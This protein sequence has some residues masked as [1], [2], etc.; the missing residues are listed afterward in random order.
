MNFIDIVNE[1][2]TT[3]VLFK[4]ALGGDG[5]TGWDWVVTAFTLARQYCDTSVK[6][7]L[8]EYNILHN[9][10]ITSNYIALIDTLKVRGLIDAI[11][12]QGHYFEFKSAA[13]LTPVYTWPISTLKSNL[14]RLAAIGLPIYIT[15]FDI[16]E[17]VDS[18][19]LQNYKTYFPIFWEHPA[20]KGITLWGY[21]EGNIWQGNA[22]LLKSGGA[23]RPAL[24]WLRSYIESPFAPVPI[25]PNGTTGEARNPL[26]V[27]HASN[28]AELYNVQVS[29][30]ST[31][32]SSIVLDTTVTDTT[33]QLSTLTGSTR[34]CWHVNTLNDQG[35]SEYSAT[36]S[37]KTENQIVSVKEFEEIPKEFKLSQNYPNPFNPPTVIN[38]QLPRTSNA[39]LKVYDM[40]GREVAT[41]VN[42]NQNAG[43]YNITFDARNLPS[44]VY[45]Y[46]INAENYSAV[47]KLVLMK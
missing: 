30:N 8:N 3:P 44:R 4:N 24:N 28:S 45:F 19:Q 15:E 22:Y 14:N 10:N 26:L 27:W 13:G 46:R 41:L 21:V 20:V 36:A 5:K 47:K 40:V 31:S 43:Y 16:N 39:N 29:I 37:F 9:D 23:E 35:T 11:G 17:P 25:S 7:I 33:L 38:Y 18:I 2:F 6:L 42:G 34:F 32:S 1:P 12:I